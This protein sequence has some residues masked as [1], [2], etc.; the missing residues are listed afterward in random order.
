MN[1]F[2]GGLVSKLRGEVIDTLLAKGQGVAQCYERPLW[3]SCG[4]VDLFLN[5]ENYEKAKVYLIPLASIV[6]KEY[7]REKHLGMTIDSQVVELHGSLYSG[8][9]T[10]IEKELDDVYLDTFIDGNVRS[11]ANGETQVFLLA[12]ENDVFYVFTHVFTTLLQGRNWT[13]ADL[14]L[15]QI[16]LDVSWGDRCNET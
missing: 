2:I 15:V 7:I 9:S 4:D 14:R 10:R 3:R 8:L 16:S 11:W 12:V 1:R 13:E 5:D 6:N